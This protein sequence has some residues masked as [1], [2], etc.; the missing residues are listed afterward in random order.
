M[1]ERVG[2]E[3]LCLANRLSFHPDNRQ[4]PYFVGTAGFPFNSAK[5]SKVCLVPSR[6]DTKPTPNAG[7]ADLVASN[8]HYRTTQLI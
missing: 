1:A 4:I 8:G 3:P 5:V 7:V 6:I 2:F